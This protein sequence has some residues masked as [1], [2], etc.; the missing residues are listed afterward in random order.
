MT[1]GEHPHPDETEQQP[2]RREVA[3]ATCGRHVDVEEITTLHGKFYLIE[4]GKDA[5]L[6][7]WRRDFPVNNPDT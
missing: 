3:C 2:E 4:D 1:D 6:E 7:A 5:L